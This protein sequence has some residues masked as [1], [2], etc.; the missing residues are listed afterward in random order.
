MLVQINTDNRVDGPQDVADGFEER[1][2]TRLSRFGDRLTRVE[3]HIRDADGHRN[4]PDGITVS[5]E[6]RPAGGQPITV[7]DTGN[8]PG[9][10]LNGALR[11]AVDALE[12]SFGKLDAVR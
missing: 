8:D 4:G 6:A 3:V 5:V 12:S 9:S 1:V 11:K 2:R 10:T 7:T